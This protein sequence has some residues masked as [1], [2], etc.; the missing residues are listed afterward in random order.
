MRRDIQLLRGLA[1]LFVVI[2]H[3]GFNFLSYGYLGVDVFFV[4]SGFLI[5]SI[6]LKDISHDKFSFKYFYLRRAKRL[7]PALYSTLAITT[8]LSLLILSPMQLK[9]YSSQL[10]GAVSFSA[11]MVLPTQISYFSNEAEGKPLLHI[12]SLSLEEQYYFFLP[13]FLF[14]I[15]NKLRIY[16]LITLLILSMAWCLAWVVDATTPEFLWRISES[17]KSEWSFYLFPTRAWELLIG[18]ICAWLILNKK[19]IKIPHSISFLSLLM[20]LLLAN[21]NFDSVHPRGD[22][23]LIALAT[24]LILLG[25]DDWV[26]DSILFKSIEKVGDWSYSIYLVHWPLFAFAFLASLGNINQ[27]TKFT[28]LILSITL[29]FMQYKWIEVPFRYGWNQKSKK[30]WLMFFGLTILLLL[31]SFLLINSPGGVN[32]NYFADIR[33]DNVGLS[34]ECDGLQS[35]NNPNCISGEPYH[36][37]VWGDSY[38]MHLVPGI[39]EHINIIQLT[40]RSCGPFLGLSRLN[41]EGRRV[42]TKNWALDCVNFNK[43]ALESIISDKNI[44]YVILS[45]IYSPYFDNTKGQFVVDD[46]IVN[47]NMTIAEEHLINTIELLLEANKTPV[48]VSAPPRSGFN[49]GECLERK[50]LSLI[51]FRTSCE[52]NMDN[53]L[54]YD[55]YVNDSISRIANKTGIKVIW[56]SDILCKGLTCAASLDGK[57]IYRDAGHLTIIGSKEIFKAINFDSYLN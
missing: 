3:A 47:K 48:L 38:A 15:P 52:I 13:L 11:N 4:L 56:L 35:I 8:A 6:I 10:I 16:A 34:V 9:E 39:S 7:L 49:I 43:K 36:V 14:L 51:T 30:T 21:V 33:Q 27:S 45:S 42:R 19:G 18:S 29:G 54:E 55:R 46:N 41:T 32:T 22:A 26:P 40:K 31:P 50:I 2:Y 44:D 5:T 17:S 25:K 20:I 23:F 37:A 1:V 24:G 53:Y 28:L 57:I 12:W